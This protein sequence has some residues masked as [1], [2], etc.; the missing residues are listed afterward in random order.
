[1]ETELHPLLDGVCSNCYKS[2]TNTQKLLICSGCK[3]SQYCSKECQKQNWKFHKARELYILTVSIEGAI[4]LTRS[5]IKIICKKNEEMRL[6]LKDPAKAVK[7]KILPE[8]KAWFDNLSLS[9]NAVT[10]NI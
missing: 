7:L 6:E 2:A 10:L 8:L 3:S 1:M 9:L 5:V 4:Q